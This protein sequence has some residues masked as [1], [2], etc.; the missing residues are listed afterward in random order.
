[1][2]VEADES[3]GTF[4]RLPSQI[5][6]VTNMDPE[7][8]DYFGSVEAMHEAYRVFMENVPF[9]GL[10]VA[11]IDHPQ[12][13]RMLAEDARRFEGRRILTY[14]VREEADLRI[15]KVLE[16]GGAIG[17]DVALGPRVRGG[18]RMLEGLSVPVPG[19]YN[20]LNGLAAI[21]VAAEAGIRDA[22]IRAGLAAFSGVKRRFSRVGSWNG[23]TFYDDYA[24][25][26]CEIASVLRAA[27]KA[28]E[29]RVI[30]LFQPH[31]YTRIHSLFDDFCRAFADADAVIVTP[32]Y[33]A[34]EAPIA[35]VD[36]VAVVEGIK[37]AGH[38]GVVSVES[39]SELAALVAEVVRPGDLVIA[40]G[41]GTITDWIGRL[42]E[43]LSGEPA[44]VGEAM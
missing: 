36:H 35:G 38:R 21:A 6:V 9:Y 8:L 26:P 42:A 20:A 3:D 41:A 44:Q 30:A 32:V 24:H 23:A 34:G 39:E 37:Q 5:G 10:V 25:H 1:M 13:R 12:V 11:C 4:T 29:G 17:F 18:A 27:R 14:G 43:R 16:R 7:H 31:R 15:L 22:D 2:V 28:A 19:L 33:S 40:L